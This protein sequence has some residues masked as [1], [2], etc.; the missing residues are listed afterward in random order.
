MT[1]RVD[2]RV[3][4]TTWLDVTMNPDGVSGQFNG[5]AISQGIEE[6][7]VSGSF[8]CLSS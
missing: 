6:F 8:N 1:W 3:F 4:I 7:E 2:G 5:R